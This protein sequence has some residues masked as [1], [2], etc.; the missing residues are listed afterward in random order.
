MR[1]LSPG[2]RGLAR[3]AFGGVLT[4]AFGFLVALASTATAEDSMTDLGVTGSNGDL[5]V[6]G[7]KVAVA[8]GDRIVM[9]DTTGKIEGVVTG[10]SDAFSLA[11]TADGSRLYAASQGSNEVAEIDT[12]TREITRRI[13][14]SDF[15]CP[16]TLALTGERL[17]VGYGGCGGDKGVLGLDLSAAVP[18]P[19][20][21]GNPLPV[22]PLLAAAGDTLVVGEGAGSPTDLFVYDLSGAHPVLRGE[23]DGH[24]Q[25]NHRLADVAV[26]PDG[27]HVI[28]AFAIP[29][30][31][32][33]WD[34]TTLT[35]VRGY[36]GPS[37]DGYPMA[38]AISSDGSFIAGARDIGTA[39]T[40]YDA[41]S[42]A[43]IRTEDTPVGEVVRGSVAFSGRD[44]FSLLKTPTDQLIL[45]RLHD[46][47][48]PPSTLTL[49]AAP[50]GTARE[51]LTLTGR[52]AFADGTAPGARP[53]IVTRTLPD[54]TSAE[55]PPATSA[56]DGTFTFTDTPPV[57]GQITYTV[58][59]D[60][61]SGHRWSKASATAAVRYGTT[62]T[63][64]GPTSAVVGNALI[65]SGELQAEGTTPP[66]KV[67][68]TI[69]RTRH[70]D[71]DTVR[72]QEGITAFGSYMFDDTPDVGEYT[73]TVR[74]GG[75]SRTGAAEASQAVTVHE[76]DE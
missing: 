31:F 75:D 19:S 26:T 69:Q 15:P 48:L 59:W 70:A 14:L 10:L 62:L 49:T 60:G 13:D 76:P 41:A 18:Q 9:A 25:D 63:L 39:M 68:I 28:S 3:L 23:I 21:F 65:F 12:A 17:W 33:V 34:A 30:S 43:V 57:G 52:L 6:G 47:T 36:Q 46:V 45:W 61:G 40:L 44:V 37:F 11:M 53:L 71:G 56:A 2:S 42:G 72:W 67:W 58:R 38:V 51:P 29:Y 7:G 16:S 54:G 20:P 1:F 5:V 4:M 73:Y 24:A 66:R 64:S 55:L 32:D 35:K 74:W 50:G 22:G 27:S 8:A